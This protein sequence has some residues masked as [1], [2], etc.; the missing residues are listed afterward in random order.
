MPTIYMIA[1]RSSNRFRFA[2]PW[3]KAVT[4]LIV[5]TT[6]VSFF[7]RIAPVFHHQVFFWFDQGLDTI[8]TKMLVVDHKI[9]LVSRYSGLAGV[10]MGPLWTWLLAIPFFLSSG[11]PAAN[12]VFFSLLSVA[13]SL[14]VYK[15]I[16]PVSPSA[17]VLSTI[18]F[19]FAPVLISYSQI[20]SSPSPISFLSVFFVWFLYQ[21]AIEK[22]VV[23]WIPL[24]LLVGVFFQMEIAV[25]IFL[26]PVIVAVISVFRQWRIFLPRYLLFGLLALGITFLPQLIFDLRHDF[27]I[28]RGIIHLFTGQNNLYGPHDSL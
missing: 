15:F 27:L 16:R 4:I 1:M 19:L 22:R 5:V 28:S 26:L 24:L 13:S 11:N 12:T 21:L 9:N 17:A 14:V 20:I 6:L 3:A 2:I 8:L 23:C 7:V 25:A 18:I 10:L